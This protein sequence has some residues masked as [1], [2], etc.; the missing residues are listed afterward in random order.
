MGLELGRISGP[1][2]SDNLLRN[3]IDLRFETDLLYLD[4]NTGKIG[5][6]SDSPTRELFVNSTIHTTNLIV[7]TQFEIPNF[8]ISSNIIQNVTG[9]I[10]IRPDQLNDPQILTDKIKTDNIEFS[11]QLIK[12]V[13]NNDSIELNPSGD[14]IVHYIT[15]TVNIDG[16]L[17]VTGNITLDGTITIGDGNTDNVIFD[18]DIK[19]NFV[20]DVDNLY[21][22][23]TNDYEWNALYSYNLKSNN[24][25]AA[26]SLI[27]NDINVI[28]EQGQTIYVS[29][30]GD[31]LNYGTHQ[32]S[33]FRTIQHALSQAS[34]GDQIIIFP[35][36]YTEEFPLTVPQGVSIRGAGIR[37]VYI[38]P[39][40]GTNT[41]DAFLLN[42]DTTI[43]FLTVQN[44]Y[45]G[46]AFKL[47][48]NFKS[49][50]KS[51]YIYNVSV[52][53]KG[54]VTSISDP[55]GYNQSDAGGGAYI[56][57]SVADPTGT[58]PPTML[59]FSATFIVPNANGL[60]ATNGV[61]VEW[62]N[63]FTY[64]ASNGIYLLNGLLGRS[65]LGTIFGA[66]LRSINSANVY[67]EYG[68]VADGESTIGYLVGHNF[69][70]IGSNADS[71]NDPRLVNQANEVFTTN[72]GTIYY[73]SVD[74]QGDFR[75]GDIF[76]VNQETGNIVFDAQSINFGA[77]GSISLE[78]PTSATYINK[79]YVQ[80]GNI[81][82]YDNDIDSLSGPVNFL[83]ISGS[84]YLNTDVFV[85]GNVN[86]S[87]DVKVKGNVFLGDTPYDT[88]TVYPKLTQDI[89][90][91]T[92]NQ[93]NLGSSSKRW[94]TL[95][96]K[97]IN[98]DNV[99][100]ITD[101]TITTITTDTDLKL[102]AAGTGTVWVKTTNVA[103]DQNLTVNNV[104]TINGTSTIQPLDIIG[105][106]TLVGNLNQ[107]GDTDII[108]TFSNY[109]IIINGDSYF[110]V[111]SIRLYDNDISAQ[112]LNDDINFVANGVGGVVLDSKIIITDNE[113]KNLWTGASTNTQKSIIFSPNGIGNTEINSTKSIIFPIGNNTNRGFSQVGE[114]RYNNLSNMVEGWSP[115]GYVNFMNL[116][117]SDRNTFITA[118]LTPG[119][120]DNT[121]RF[122]INET[123]KATIDST[124]LT[125]NTMHIDNVSIS[126]NN[127]GNLITSTD[128][129]LIPPGTGSV[130]VNEILIK[131][132]NVTNT[133]DSA[134]IIQNTG[135]GYTKFTGT[136][137]VVFAIGSTDDRRDLPELG[138]TRY[139][140][141]LGYMEVFNGTDWLAATGASGNITESEAVDIMDIWS[142][143]LG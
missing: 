59:F 2:L 118:E 111:P 53:T 80:T 84:T 90:P 134:I 34:L 25:T 68:V 32:H 66:E 99:T 49:L 70:Y 98:I 26:T 82:I 88:I 137:G 1:L 37:A 24:I 105:D 22:L 43:E 97:L 77:S 135:P 6:R 89:N 3:G 132:N 8:L 64:F 57:G 23:G 71:T 35:G 69:G 55:L 81:R 14:G 38:Q 94:N 93:W 29:I 36:T 86:I 13:I 115:S 143:I 140:T 60:V 123:V 12:N 114:V 121:L 7:D 45:Q 120:N 31:D 9:T 91:G 110:E 62:L 92:T 128:I 75:I 46:Y 27:L 130:N 10:Y 44:F 136:G 50:N 108:G 74:H 54:S 125:T 76:Y 58:I 100:Q 139:N 67:G 101:N 85:T 52:I 83:A 109:N 117:D 40:S 18:S 138:E 78:G 73:E 41:N 131:D 33:T 56:D 133:V 116:W 102:V 124:S 5:V 28:L 39:T 15:D 16:S 47:A 20:P 142:L 4:V 42:G 72:N 96:N 51:P 61:R 65:S 63:S 127:I 122:G 48:T 30:N 119:A 126:G 19:S 103:I 113:I 104:L 95:Y 141:D 107:T 11:N 17:R 129:E 87:A 112:Y 21:T 79:D 106:I